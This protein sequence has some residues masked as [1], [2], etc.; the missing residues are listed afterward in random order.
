M[1]ENKYPVG[2]ERKFNEFLVREY[3]K[4]GSV[5]EVFRVH[6]WGI[7]ISYAGYQRVLNKWGIVKAAGPNSKL[8][9]ML[10]FFDHMTEENVNF[11]KLYK[12][13]P[14]SYMTSA[15]TLYR[16]LAYIREGVTRRMGT[17]LVISPHGYENKIL[18]GKDVSTPRIELGKPYGSISIPLGFSRKRDPREDA[19]LRVLQQ[20]VFCKKAIKQEMPD[21]IPSHPKPFMFLDVADVRVEVF[22]I[23][24]P[25][26]YSGKKHFSSFKL[27]DHK[28]I[29]INQVI[30]AK[31]SSNFRVGLKEVGIGYQKYLELRGRKM[32]INP[33]LYKSQ[34]NYQLAQVQPPDHYR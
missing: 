23:K 32:A 22:H 7:P 3:L 27:N 9:E 5:D 2:S 34:L 33:L 13:M 12:K 11:E 26:N 19:I 16:I 17:A 25:K 24:L 30:N 10:G 6:R 21:I 31:K 4:Y 15:A 8:S 20:E 28:F 18:V 29:S 14:P 1:V